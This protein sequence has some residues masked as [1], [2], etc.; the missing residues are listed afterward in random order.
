MTKHESYAYKEEGEQ[1][2]EILLWGI[3][4]LQQH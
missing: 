4:E 2:Q 3:T 1:C